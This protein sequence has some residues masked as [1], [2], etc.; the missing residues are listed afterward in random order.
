MA[1]VSASSAIPAAQRMRS[2]SLLA[3]LSDRPRRGH[4]VA[5]TAGAAPGAGLSCVTE[6]PMRTHPYVRAYMAGIIVP[7]VF[8]LAQTEGG[9]L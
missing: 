5:D 8:L 9:T 6:D 7:T 3:R 2:S 1:G 4:R